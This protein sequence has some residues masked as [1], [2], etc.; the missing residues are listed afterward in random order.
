M[1]IL[2]YFEGVAFFE[3]YC[4]TGVSEISGKKYRILPQL[5]FNLNTILWGR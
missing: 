3:Q 1:A 2:L 4:I 5:T